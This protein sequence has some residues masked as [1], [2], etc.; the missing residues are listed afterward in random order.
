MDTT[1]EIRPVKAVNTA[2]S[3]Y[4]HD[5]TPETMPDRVLGTIGARLVDS[6]R[7]LRQK[8]A[9]LVGG[10]GI[11][12]PLMLALEDA[13]F[14][15]QGRPTEKLLYETADIIRRRPIPF[16]LIGATLGFLLAR[17]TRR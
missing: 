13:G 9:P 2:P 3:Q 15:L 10:S 11:A 5:Q 16:M 7:A 4:G 8:A 14:F 17:G 6:A 12:I 1:T